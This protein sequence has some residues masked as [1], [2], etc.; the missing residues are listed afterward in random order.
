[1]YTFCKRAATV[2]AV[3]VFLA[4]APSRAESPAYLENLVMG[5]PSA[6]VSDRAKPDNYLLMRKQYALSYNNSKGTP[7]WVSWHLSKKWLGR[8]RRGNAF[9]PDP[10][11]PRGFL[12]VRPTDYRGSG[13]DRGHMCPAADRSVSKEDMDATF[14]MTNMVPQAPD[15]NRKT[16]EKLEAY[17][18]DQARE[19]KELFILAGPAGRGGTGE[20]GK[21]NVL[22]GK[23]VVPASCWKVVLI[24]PAGT[25]DPKRVAAASA[26]AFAVIMPNE[27]NLKAN[28]RDY[29]VTVR[30]VE[31]LTGFN[32]WDKLP[33]DVSKELKQR[34]DTRARPAP[35]GPGGEVKADKN[36]VLPEFVI[37]CVIGNKRSKK[38]H[39]P[40][41]RG[42]A[43]ARK[44]K[45]AIFFQDEGAAKKAG[46]ARAK[47]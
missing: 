44:S 29:A 15:L 23:V 9:A 34:K 24:L 33:A 18:R 38:Y 46:Y 22:R 43:R 32:F 12:V 31:K 21:K 14:Y 41:G 47:R 8:A 42:S 13:F 30:E 27:Q 6:A 19:N 40:G 39:L 7:N 3:C 5:N 2:L 17:C 4:T 1:M 35:K 16:W 36:G 45:N 37:G 26:R 20:K 11:L 25:T 10:A 28:W